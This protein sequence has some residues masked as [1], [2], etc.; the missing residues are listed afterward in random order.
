[1]TVDHERER[2]RG[3]GGTPIQVAPFVR[4]N[5]A[6]LI[7]VVPIVIVVLRIAR[8]SNFDATTARGVLES[9]GLVQ[10]IAGTLLPL[11]PTALFVSAVALSVYAFRE[12]TALARMSR[13]LAPPVAIFCLVLFPWGILALLVAGV[14]VVLAIEWR[15]ARRR[16][17][18]VFASFDS[19]W[20]LGAAALLVAAQILIYGTMWLPPERIE[21]RRGTAAVG[22]VLDAG[23]VWTSVLV[24]ETR[25]IRRF[26]TE[27]LQS[28]TV[29]QVEGAD[30]DGEDSLVDL[31]TGR[32]RPKYP[33]C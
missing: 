14:L 25:S 28:R 15:L 4:R 10:V 26:R 12:R 30:I 21:T 29:C 11:V 18:R 19:N 27:S 13:V 7:P 1:L 6:V 23:F 24:E 2:S 9:A 20:F 5:A 3:T 31:V 8:V 16:S 32:R 22:Y 33:E 17:R